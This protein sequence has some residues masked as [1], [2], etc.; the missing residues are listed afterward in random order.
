MSTM[1]EDQKGLSTESVESL[2]K[3][4]FA[5]THRLHAVDKAATQYDKGS[6]KRAQVEADAQKL[7]DD[8]DIISR[9]I[10]RRA[11]E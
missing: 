8:R 2:L 11:G 4:A 9:E 5:L 10:Q 3:K 1:T 6:A 7:R